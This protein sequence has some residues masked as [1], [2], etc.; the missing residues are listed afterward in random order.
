M[1]CSLVD[2][3]SNYVKFLSNDVDKHDGEEDISH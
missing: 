1:V 2:S 3:Q